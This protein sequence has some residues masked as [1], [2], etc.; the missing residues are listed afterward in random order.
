MRQCA[1]DLARVVVAS[2][3]GIAAPAI[4]TRNLGASRIRVI[5]GHRREQS[6]RVARKDGDGLQQRGVAPGAV[7]LDLRGYQG[8]AEGG[9]GI[10][11]VQRFLVNGAA[12]EGGI[13]GE[14]EQDAFGVCTLG[15]EW[16]E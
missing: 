16:S 1:S 5:A 13:G 8:V 14:D 9:C 6:S 15:D 3:A 4:M 7:S 12:L 2:W 11:A 10:E